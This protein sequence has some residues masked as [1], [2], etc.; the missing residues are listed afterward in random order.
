[1]RVVEPDVVRGRDCVL[2]DDVLTSGATLAE[3]RRALRA[4]GARSVGMAVCMVTPRRL[5]ASALPLSRP[6]D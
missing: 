4:A 2:V 3:G 1:M 5:P 6:P